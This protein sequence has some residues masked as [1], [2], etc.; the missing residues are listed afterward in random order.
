MK[1]TICRLRKCQSNYKIFQCP[2][3]IT[4]NKKH[5]SKQTVSSTYAME[6][7]VLLLLTDCE[8]FQFE[9]SKKLWSV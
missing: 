8:L 6:K 7:N 4:W 9:Q 1:A 2:L 3:V 5:S